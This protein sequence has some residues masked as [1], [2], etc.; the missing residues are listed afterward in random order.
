MFNGAVLLLRDVTKRFWDPTQRTQRTVLKD[1][2]L[3]LLPGCAAVITGPNGAGKSTF[4]RILATLLLPD[5]GKLELNGEVLGC[6]TRAVTGY[7]TGEERSF[8]LRLSVEE[9]LRFFAEL[10]GMGAAHRRQQIQLLGERLGLA[11]MLRAPVSELSQGLR[12]RVGFAR[13]L[14]H[15]PA[16]L[17]LDEPTRSQDELGRT[18]M[19]ELCQEHLSRGNLLVL[20]THDGSFMPE[21]ARHTLREGQLVRGAP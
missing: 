4:L 5:E 17:L 14:L 11:S 12:D 21:L 9:N 15:S 7:A 8:Q 20:A 3:R 1:V 2:A 18:L 16:L 6:S 10:H 19:A 13:A